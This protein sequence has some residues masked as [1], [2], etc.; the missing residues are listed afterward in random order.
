MPI[1]FLSPQSKQ[2][3]HLSV[4]KV[5]SYNCRYTIYTTMVIVNALIVHSYNCYHIKVPS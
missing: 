1:A 2:Q 5:H 4:N 3:R